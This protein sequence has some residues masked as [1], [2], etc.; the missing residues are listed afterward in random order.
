M[1]QVELLLDLGR[2]E[3]MCLHLTTTALFTTYN[4]LIQHRA[5]G[6]ALH[7]DDAMHAVCIT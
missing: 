5:R 2:L 7:L 4:R 1:V 3:V 6:I